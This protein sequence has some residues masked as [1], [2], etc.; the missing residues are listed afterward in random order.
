MRGE[1]KREKKIFHV[2]FQSFNSENNHDR[3]RSEPRVE[4]SICGGREPRGESS[5]LLCWGVRIC[6]KALEL[7]LK[8][9][10]TERG[11]GIGA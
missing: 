10:E 9:V 8:A 3:A 7:D 6:N 4:N 5:V 1:K 2:L 11:M